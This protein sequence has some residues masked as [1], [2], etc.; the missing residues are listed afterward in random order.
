[1]ENTLLADIMNIA[2]ICA[3]QTFGYN[4]GMFSVDLAAWFFLT[5]NFPNS[6]IRFFT[7]YPPSGDF[8]SSPFNY[9]KREEFK[10]WNDDCDVILYWGDFLHG[11]A[12]KKAMEKWLAKH[13]PSF[14]SSKVKETVRSFLYRKGLPKKSN[15]KIIVYGGTILFN[16]WS[17]HADDTYHNDLKY[18]LN[19][20]DAVWMRDPF[21]T[22]EIQYLTQN[23]SHTQG[24]DCALFLSKSFLKNSFASTKKNKSIGFFFGRSYLNIQAFSK[25][26]EELKQGNYTEVFWLNWGKPPFFLNRY[27]EVT[28]HINNLDVRPRVEEPLNVLQTLTSADIIISDTYHV[29]VNAWNL[30]IPAICIIDDISPSLPVNSGENNWRDKR[31]SFYWQYNFSPFLVYISSLSKAENAKL[32]AEKISKLLSEHTTVTKMLDVLDTHS[33]TL[34]KKLRCLLKS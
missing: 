2:V 31:V 22:S 28:K 20:A 29:C 17:D 14:D 7:L 13:E 15:Q 5:Q 32:I 16:N 11:Y 24:T 21:S 10:K 8:H 23:Y 12:Y 6:T 26:L 30:G 1:M 9:E 34:Q 3:P 33:N 25:L 27:E 19:L 4:T 18:L